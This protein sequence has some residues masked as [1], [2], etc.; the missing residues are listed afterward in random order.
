MITSTTP[1]QIAAMGLKKGQKIALN[2]N[3]FRS[4]YTFDSY[5]TGKRVITAYSVACTE[6]SCNNRWSWENI[7]H[8]TRSRK[9]VPETYPL[10]EVSIEPCVSD[11]L[12]KGVMKK[13]TRVSYL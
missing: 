7:S 1:E 13:S 5:D 2:K 10:S 12:P 4:E 6:P 3:G 8:E 11:A 9:P